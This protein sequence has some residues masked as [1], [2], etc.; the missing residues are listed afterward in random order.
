MSGPV[1]V[2][3]NQNTKNTTQ[4]TGNLILKKLFCFKKEKKQQQIRGCA[5]P[6]LPQPVGP[7][8]HEPWE[9]VLYIGLSSLESVKYVSKGQGIGF[10]DQR[11][12]FVFCWLFFSA[13]VRLFFFF[14]FLLTF[15]KSRCHS[16]LVRGASFTSHRT[17]QKAAA[18]SSQDIALWIKVFSLSRP[19]A[20][21]MRLGRWAS[22]V[23]DCLSCP[24]SV[25][26]AG[27]ATWRRCLFIQSLAGEFE[28]HPC[29]Y[30]D[31]DFFISSRW[32]PQK[33]RESGRAIKHGM[34]RQWNE[35]RREIQMKDDSV[36]RD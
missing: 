6:K 24:S 18:P 15:L 2:W 10:A 5:T 7:V 25:S 27:G 29:T 26:A 21:F 17:A 35:G 28:C 11:I 19:S 30:K 20:V 3:A 14:F 4:N 9:T 32:S 1:R 22:Y 34:Q 8:C 36:D 13:S 16:A 23:S 12:S 31:K 33:K